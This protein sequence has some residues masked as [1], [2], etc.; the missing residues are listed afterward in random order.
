MRMRCVGAAL[1]GV[2][3]CAGAQAA[4]VERVRE[5]TVGPKNFLD[6]DDDTAVDISGF[7]C[8]AVPARHCLAVNDEN[9]TAQFARIE[10]GRIAPGDEIPL[11]DKPSP[12]TLGT[13]PSVA[14]PKGEKKFKE[15]DGEAVA[16]AAPYFYVVGSHGCGRKHDVFRLSSFILARVRVNAEGQPVDAHGNILSAADA[17]RAVETT[18]RLA[19]VLPRAGEAGAAF[20]KSLNGANGL[21]IEGLAVIEDRLLVG[22]RAPSLNGNAFIVEASI[23]DLFAPGH[24]RSQSAPKV[25]PIDLGADTGIRDIARHG[26]ELLVLSGPAQNQS[27]PYTLSLFE[28]KEGAKARPIGAVEIPDVVIDG[29]RPKAEG[30]TILDVQGK[31]LRVLIMFD[32]LP[33]GGPREYR[34]TLD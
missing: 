19:D 6:D 18:Y 4:S 32:L 26:S 11:I 16:Y 14:C 20:G 13:A 5:Y 3:L 2:L 29:E 17:G 22:L 30:L 1:L 23:A 27:G 10:D 7:A 25:L 33:N 21:N 28:P 34:V 31:T 12:S 24:G 8:T 15:F 9:Q